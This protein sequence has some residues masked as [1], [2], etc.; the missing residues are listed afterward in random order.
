MKKLV[1]FEIVAVECDRMDG[2]RVLQLNLSKD[3][4]GLLEGSRIS[5]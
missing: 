5:D 2:N 3:G 4:S 1:G